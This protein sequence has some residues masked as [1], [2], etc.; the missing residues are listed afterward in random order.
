MNSCEDLCTGVQNL[1]AT[2]CASSGTIQL[3]GT[4]EVALPLVNSTRTRS[5]KAAR[6]TYVWPKWDRNQAQWS[7]DPACSSE[8]L[9]AEHEQALS[10]RRGLFA[11]GKPLGWAYR[12]KSTSEST[13]K[14]IAGQSG[15]RGN[16][17]VSNCLPGT[18]APWR[19]TAKTGGHR[20][21]ETVAWILEHRV[22]LS[23]SVPGS[24][25]EP[26]QLALYFER[27]LFF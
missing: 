13:S 1:L 26:F 4:I 27:I 23:R 16:R 2:H 18:Y 19:K 8:N 15:Y 5:A 24:G 3:P 14:T 22:P 21:L 9:R 10:C 11:E 20:V 12:S 7:C 17:G 6:R 25:G